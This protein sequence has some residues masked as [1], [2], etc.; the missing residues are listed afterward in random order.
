MPFRFVHM[1][2]ACGLTAAFLVAGLSAYRILK[3]DPKHA[4]RLTLKS[5]VFAAAILIPLQIIAGDMHGLNTLEHQPQKIAA[6]EGLWETEQGA[7]LVLFAWPDEEGRDNRY[8]LEIPNLAS[9]I[10][11]HEME[12]ELKGLSEFEEYPPVAPVFWGFRIMV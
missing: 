6:M 10:L 3:G 5:G 11:T 9:L 7:P 8:A 2:L 4:P 12:G 1:M